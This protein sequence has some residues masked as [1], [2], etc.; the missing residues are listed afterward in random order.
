MFNS[1]SMLLQPS[2]VSDLYEPYVEMERL[3]VLNDWS[4]NL[5]EI[6]VGIAT[7]LR[8]GRSWFQ[9]SIPGGGWE[10]FSSPSRPERLWGPT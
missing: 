9:G 3:Q 8:A 6:S 7:R 1:R 5:R 2:M 4:A 10:N